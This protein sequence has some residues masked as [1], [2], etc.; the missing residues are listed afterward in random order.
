MCNFLLHL[1]NYPTFPTLAHSVEISNF[2]ALHACL[3]ILWVL[4]WQV[5][6]ATVF[7]QLPWCA[8]LVH[9]YFCFA[10]LDFSGYFIL[11]NCPDSV[12]MF[13]TVTWALCTSTLLAHANTSPLVIHPLFFA[14]F[15]YFIISSSIL[16]SF[17][18]CINCSLS[19]LLTS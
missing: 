14:V 19:C 18:P 2:V 7:A 3:V 11:S 1:I 10:C 17:S 13:K 4:S 15:N 6:P 9:Q 16:L 8:A 5:C 12:N